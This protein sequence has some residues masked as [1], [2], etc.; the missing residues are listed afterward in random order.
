MTEKSSPA[1]IWLLIRSLRP[2][3]WP[4]NLIAF[5]PLLFSLKILQADSIYAA[6]LCVLA[7]CLAS[8]CVY[9]VNDLLD[10]NSDRLHPHK[11]L[12]PIASGELSSSLAA[13]MAVICLSAAIALSLAVRGQLLLTVAIYL[14]L[15]AFYVT[16]FKHHPILDVFSI[17]GGFVL[18]AI[19]GAI[20]IKVLPSGWLLLCTSLGALFLALEKRRQEIN[21]LKDESGDHRQAL[22]Y[23]TPEIL[24]RF[25]A[26]ILPSL[27]TC[28]AFY[29][30]LSFHGHWMLLT[31]PFV[32]YGIMRYQM[33]S[34]AGQLVGA[35]EDVFWRDRPM[36]WT[37]CL[38]LLTC[39][40]VAYK[41]PETLMLWLDTWK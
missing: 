7:L 8:S 27:L 17:A 12:R 40:L 1:T 29:S 4:K 28:Y 10:K 19:A 26:L 13:F 31:V 38:W 30:F 6:C 9:I 34:A 5:L 25:E 37:L 35:P 39:A 11:K 21:L 18:R 16:I 3:Q 15:S 2:R 23:Y 20:A 32:L 22:R 41:T 36:Q 24:D 33:L 14:L